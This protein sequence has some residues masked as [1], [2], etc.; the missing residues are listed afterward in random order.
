MFCIVILIRLHRS[1]TNQWQHIPNY[2]VYSIKSLLWNKIIYHV[3]WNIT[4]LSSVNFSSLKC[5]NATC[6]S[7]KMFA[8]CGL[9]VF[10]HCTR[11]LFLCP[12]FSLVIVGNP[13][14]HLR[15]ISFHN[16]SFFSGS[17]LWSILLKM[18]RVQEQDFHEPNSSDLEDQE[19]WS[20]TLVS[21]SQ[22]CIT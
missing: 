12:V 17:G 19:S 4:D 5:T 18:S 2:L 11:T 3:T 21:R 9:F 6:N 14:L 20:K 1:V 7:K 22:D 8:C 10:V 15:L 13:S 16:L